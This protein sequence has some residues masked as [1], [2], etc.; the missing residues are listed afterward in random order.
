MYPLVLTWAR[1]TLE[2]LLPMKKG[3]KCQKLCSS[4]VLMVPLL[5]FHLH[6]CDN[7]VLLITEHKERYTCPSVPILL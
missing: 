7:N 4:L 2:D 3:K 6:V 1:A 5:R